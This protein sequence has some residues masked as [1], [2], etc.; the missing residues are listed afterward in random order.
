M[1]FC[2]FDENYFSLSF[3]HWQRQYRRQ[4]YT[5]VISFMKHGGQVENG[6]MKK[7]TISFMWIWVMFFRL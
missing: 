1:A 3:V 5:N 6:Q 4:D 2:G 7:S